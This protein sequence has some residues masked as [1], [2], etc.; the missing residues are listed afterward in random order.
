VKEVKRAR[1]F[2]IAYI[3][4]DK[5]LVTNTERKLSKRLGVSCIE[6]LEII[7]EMEFIYV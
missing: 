2:Y 6:L 7:S 1:F 5:R 4:A 3:H